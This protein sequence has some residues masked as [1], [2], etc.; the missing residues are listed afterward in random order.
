MIGQ[1]HYFPYNQIREVKRNLTGNSETSTYSNY[2]YNKESFYSAYNNGKPDLV[3]LGD[4]LT[5]IAEW[6]EM[7]PNYWWLIED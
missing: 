4:S 6:Q 1:Y 7:F 5:D 3:F 2:Y